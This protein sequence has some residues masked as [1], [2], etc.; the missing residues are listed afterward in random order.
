MGRRPSI[1]ILGYTEA[2]T[3]L[4]AANREGVG[5]VIAIHGFR[6]FPVDAG[7]IKHVLSLEFD[8]CNAPVIDDPLAAAQF[9]IRQRDAAEVGLRLQ[10]PTLN[11]AVQIIEFATQIA[12]VGGTLLCHCLAGVGRSPAAALI[13]L[14]TW[15]HPGEELDCMREVLAA[16]PCAIPNE[17]LVAF[18]D[19][20][21]G[22]D[23]R[24][25]SALRALRP[26]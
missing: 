2:A 5:A 13:C 3:T 1:L 22:R 16:R 4:K 14:A 23:G 7:A 19:S 10:P 6:E 9:R 18:A 25:I 17:S 11:H 21:L 8:D 26:G 12:N 15:T 20:A 24:L